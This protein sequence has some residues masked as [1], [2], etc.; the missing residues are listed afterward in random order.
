[1][2]RADQRRDRKIGEQFGG[3]HLIAAVEP[4]QAKHVLPNP[5]WRQHHRS[6]API[7]A[8][9]AAAQLMD[10]AGDG[11]D[12]RHVVKIAGESAKVLASSAQNFERLVIPRS[13]EF[14]VNTAQRQQAPRREQLF[15][16]VL[17]VRREIG[18]PSRVDF[19]EQRLPSGPIYRPAIVRVD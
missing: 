12:K 19:V 2:E 9:A 17:P 8:L 5:A 1:M 11:D 7:G 3:R 16:P 15:T 13:E 10:E 14:R 6:V 18:R 4:A